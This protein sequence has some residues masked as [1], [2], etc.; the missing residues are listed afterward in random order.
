MD[1]PNPA[2]G[3][4]FPPCIKGP[5]R[6]CDRAW[7]WVVASSKSSSQPTAQRNSRSLGFALVLVPCDSEEPRLSFPVLPKIALID[8]VHRG[9]DPIRH[10]SCACSLEARE[11]PSSPMTRQSSSSLSSAKKN[12]FSPVFYLSLFDINCTTATLCPPP[13]ARN[14]SC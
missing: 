2:E 8:C 14:R 9:C 11:K 5:G 4:L 12:S 6:G 1:C 3:G 10:P 7:D 13:S